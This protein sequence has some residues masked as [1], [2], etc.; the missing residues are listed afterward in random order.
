MRQFVGDD[1]YF[2]VADTVTNYIHAYLDIYSVTIH[3]TKSWSLTM[4]DGDRFI[5]FQRLIPYVTFLII[6]F[7]WMVMIMM[8]KVAIKIIKIVHFIVSC[9]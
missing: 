8:L 6:S 3:V 1:R 7:K 4:T 9:H 5:Q 2:I